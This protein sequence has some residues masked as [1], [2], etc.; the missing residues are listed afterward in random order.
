[1]RKIF[2]RN[3]Y[4]ILIF[5]SLV[6]ILVSCS[7]GDKKYACTIGSGITMACGNET[8]YMCRQLKG[9][10]HEGSKCSDFGYNSAQLDDIGS[11]AWSEL[12]F[13]D[14]SKELPSMKTRQ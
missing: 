1:M 9:T 12:V 4:S 7:G 5:L 13:A 2:Y 6:F 11:V 14:F 10:F 3:N 8:P